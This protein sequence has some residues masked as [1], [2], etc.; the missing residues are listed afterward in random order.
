[1]T[2]KKAIAPH[3]MRGFTLAELMTTLVVVAV[4]ASVAYPSYQSQ[5]LKSKRSEGKA[6]L[7]EVMQLQER[8][9][10][11]NGSYTA[12]LTQ[13]GLPAAGIVSEHEY[14]TVIVSEATVTCPITDCLVLTSNATGANKN[15]G[16]LRLRSDSEKN[17]KK[18][19]ISWQQGWPDS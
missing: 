6:L 17:W 1:M 12:D 15:H 9:K 16:S 7:F 2:M 3:I 19:D 4:L 8:F 5:I 11:E 13:L 10:T 14:Y 18:S